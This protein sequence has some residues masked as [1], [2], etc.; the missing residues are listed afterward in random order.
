MTLTLGEMIEKMEKWKKYDRGYVS[1]D[2][3][4]ANPTRLDSY[5]GYYERLALGFDGDHC[6]K[7]VTPKQFYEM[8]TEA[9]GMVYT[10]WKGGEYT[11]NLGT[12]VHVANPGNISDTI[13]VDIIGEPYFEDDGAFVTILTKYD[14]D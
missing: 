9:N 7:T 14:P 3:G 13:I 6:S 5:R 8:L 10:G 1:F 11:M 2:F 12:W 4:S